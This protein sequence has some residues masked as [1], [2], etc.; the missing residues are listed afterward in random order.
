M[1]PCENPL[2]ERVEVPQHN[3]QWLRAVV[4]KEI[5]VFQYLGFVCSA[6]A[7]FG[8]GKVQCSLAILGFLVTYMGNQT[9][10]VT[11]RWRR[12]SYFPVATYT[13]VPFVLGAFTQAVAFGS[14][15]QKKGTWLAIASPILNV[16]GG[17]GEGFLAETFCKQWMHLAAVV[18][19]NLGL[20]AQKH[21]LATISGT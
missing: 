1:A 8:L 3:N 14:L 11:K 6:L 9:P 19:F 15:V 16:L 2:Y 18:L 21:V 4:Y 20:W 13:L 5:F 10:K 7:V 17:V 12:N